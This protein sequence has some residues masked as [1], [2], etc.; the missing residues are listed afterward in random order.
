MKKSSSVT[1]V[2]RKKGSGVLDAKRKL[3][4]FLR[5]QNIAF[6]VDDHPNTLDGLT[7]TDTLNIVSL[8]QVQHGI[9]VSLGGDGSLLRLIDHASAHGLS[10][11]GINLGR[12]GFLTDLSMDNLDGLTQ[13]LSGDYTSDERG[14]L[15]VSGVSQNQP[16]TLGVALNDMMISA[17]KP[18]KNLDFT[19]TI[20][21]KNEF[22]HHADGFLVSTP[23][24]STAYAL[25]AGGPIIHPHLDVL[26]LTSI[27]SH[28]LSTRPI[29]VPPE[30]EITIKIGDLVDRRAVVCTDGTP[31]DCLE[32]GATIKICQS[33]RKL[34]LIHPEGYDFF[35]A[36]QHKLRWEFA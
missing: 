4:D 10:L 12:V 24:G 23:T 29:V 11:V 2:A 16:T 5:L 7:E 36:A 31:V 33:K 18:G 30:T 27:C 14:L 26:L 20:D 8:D 25:S 6:Q 13:L 21:G 17:E 35:K 1:L 22:R 34:R 19:V 15:E 28:R 32:P 3:I 9:L